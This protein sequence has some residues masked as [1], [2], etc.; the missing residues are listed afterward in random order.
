MGQQNST[1][2]GLAEA[3]ASGDFAAGF[4]QFLEGLTPAQRQELAKAAASAAGLDLPVP[5]GA[6]VLADYYTE[7]QLAAQLGIS[8]RTLKRWRRARDGP[9]Y[10]VI[11]RQIY[12][13]RGAVEGWLRSRE[14]GFEDSKG[15]SRRTTGR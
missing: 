13:R 8:Q 12:F 5:N 7:Q 9:P 1:A 3:T 2:T 10:L 14:R 6:G 15:R 11:S 4:A